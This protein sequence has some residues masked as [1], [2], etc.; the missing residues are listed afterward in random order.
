LDKQFSHTGQKHSILILD[1]NPPF[2]QAAINL[3]KHYTQAEVLGCVSKDA[4]L[5]YALDNH[6]A[7]VLVDMDTPQSCGVEA[8]T[9]LRKLLPDSKIVAMSM[10]NDPGFQKL[11]CSAGANALIYK[12]DLENQLIPQFFARTIG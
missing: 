7:L 5:A 2:L 6:P 9:Q 11:A 3:M 1:D 8:I 12:P 10:L 4:A